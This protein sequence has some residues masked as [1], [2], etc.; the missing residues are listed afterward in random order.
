M[1]RFDHKYCHAARRLNLGTIVAIAK[2]AII[3]DASV[4]TDK[5]SCLKLKS[6]L[7]RPM[8]I[9]SLYASTISRPCHVRSHVFVAIHRRLYRVYWSP[10]TPL[11]RTLACLDPFLH[12]VALP[13]ILPANMTSTDSG[14]LLSL[15]T[16]LDFFQPLF[17][18]IVHLRC[19]HVS[20]NSFRKEKIHLPAALKY[21]FFAS[22]RFGW[23]PIP[24]SV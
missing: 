6:F 11:C 7:K 15:S 3:L 21:H 8:T 5:F 20:T 10:R 16:P 24:T 19:T 12:H 13:F 1:C 4:R 22:S 17:G 18:S 14:L 9:S 23:H 2:I